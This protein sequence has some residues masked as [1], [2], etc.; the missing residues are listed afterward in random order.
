VDLGS[1][2]PWWIEGETGRKFPEYLLVPG[3]LIN[4]PVVI[5]RVSQTTEGMGVWVDADGQQC[6]A[7]A[8]WDA[9]TILPGTTPLKWLLGYGEP[10]KTDVCQ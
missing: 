4:P 3:P 10:S 7:D 5:M 1:D 9:D 8:I 2:D 6:I